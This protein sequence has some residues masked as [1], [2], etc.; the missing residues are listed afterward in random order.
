MPQLSLQ[1]LTKTFSRVTAVDRLTLDVADG[2]LLALV[3]PSGCGK[4]TTLRMIAGLETPSG[5]TISI[6]GQDVTHQ[7]ARSRDVAMVFQ[8]LAIYPHLNVADNLA[9]GLR[10][11]GVPR[12]EARRRVGETAEMLAI[13]DLL[14][15]LPRELSGGQRQRVA[16]GRAIVRQPRLFLLDEPLAQLDEPLRNE[17]R[18]EIRRLHSRFGITTIFV[19]HDQAEALQLG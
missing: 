12:H 1:L 3:G 17:L 14:G 11:R 9:F 19:T 4:S 7:S 10:M 16:L 18:G 8:D 15:R 2:E 5:G 13:G 6:A